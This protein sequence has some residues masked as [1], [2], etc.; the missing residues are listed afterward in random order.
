MDKK[1]KK[2]D[3]YCQNCGKIGHLYKKC[4][5]PITSFGLIA[6]K[7]VNNIDISLPNKKN[8][9]K[10]KEI[11]NV[12]LNKTNDDSGIIKKHCLFKE[13]KKNNE[14]IKYLLVRRRDSLSYVEFIRGRYNIEDV[15]FI[16]TM[17]REMTKDER[18][19][20][21]IDTFEN[22]WNHL[23]MNKSNHNY[24]NEYDISYGKYLKIKEGFNHNGK[25]IN[26]DLLLTKIQ[27][28]Y[29]YPEWGFAKGRRNNKE[30][31]LDCAER[32]FQEETGFRKGEYNIIHQLDKIDEIFIGSN[33]VNYKH[34]YFIAHCPFN[35]VP[36]INSHNKHQA[37]EVGDIG[38]FSYE[39]CNKIFRP[40]DV[41]KKELLGKVHNVL[42]N[43]KFTE[44]D[45]LI[46]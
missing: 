43:L 7:R 31:D 21:E 40:C 13:N 10:V 41:E 34:T 9:S 42:K 14:I 27:S 17:F 18:K 26:L 3:I 39:E 28:V 8:D 44:E 19:K 6:F 37:Y 35:K 23:W 33:K 38:W 4:L 32:E 29:D 16:F 36:K 12:D 11:N 2:K 25:L 46:I 30:K 22:L 20:I 15:D 1:K 24:K 45:V 5:E